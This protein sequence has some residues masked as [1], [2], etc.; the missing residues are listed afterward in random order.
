MKMRNRDSR[1]FWADG[2]KSDIWFFDESLI[3]EPVFFFAV[4]I[5]QG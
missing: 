4:M 1:G 2:G 5:Y 3:E